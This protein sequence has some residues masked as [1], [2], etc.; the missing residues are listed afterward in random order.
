MLTSRPNSYQNTHARRQN[1]DKLQAQL[2]DAENIHP[3]KLL[4][5][6][7]TYIGYLESQLERVTNACLTVQ[8]FDQRIETVTSAARLLE[9]KVLNTG[10]L[11]KCSQSYAEENES[12]QKQAVAELTRRTQQVEIAV[13]SGDQRQQQWEAA[14]DSAWQ[15]RLDALEQ[16]MLSKMDRALAKF[17]EKQLGVGPQS[18][19]VMLP[20]LSSRLSHM[21]QSVSLLLSGAPLPADMHRADACTKSLEEVQGVLAQEM[22]GLKAERT[23]FKDLL[24]DAKWTAVQAA[25]PDQATAQKVLDGIQHKVESEI[26]KG[27]DCLAQ[28][29]AELQALAHG[30]SSSRSSKQQEPPGG[31][32]QPAPR[33]QPSGLSHATDRLMLRQQHDQPSLRAATQRAEQGLQQHGEQAAFQQP[34]AI[35]Q[36]QSK[37]GVPMSPKRGN[38]ELSRSTS[39]QP[40]D[41]PGAAGTPHKRTMQRTA[42]HLSPR[43]DQDKAQAGKR[44]WIPGGSVKQK[45]AATPVKLTTS[46]SDANTAGGHVLQRTIKRRQRLQ[47]LY[48]ELQSLGD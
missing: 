44:Q 24:H 10:R 23:K 7:S 45:D 46:R 20:D 40:P 6:R 28:A 11:L 25:G 32:A 37:E 3:D 33:Q 31:M 13:S 30:L 15:G 39:R 22:Q 9:E 41:S 29:K 5:D 36:T 2:R 8:S 42:S 12:L 16:R 19:P 21:E 48:A 1:Y 4:T 47:E 35:A 26:R 18:T 17:L 38:I 27:M 34:P 43:K 14:Q